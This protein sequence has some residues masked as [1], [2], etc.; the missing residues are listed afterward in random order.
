MPALWAADRHIH[1][2]STKL[3]G[4]VGAQRI[5]KRCRK[6]FLPRTDPVLV[7]GAPRSIRYCDTCWDDYAPSP[8]ALRK[9]SRR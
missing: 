1:N 8:R 2:V 6:L 9:K 5:C 4:P 7:C 3:E